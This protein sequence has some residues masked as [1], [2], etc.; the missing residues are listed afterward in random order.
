MQPLGGRPPTSAHYGDQEV[1]E[2]GRFKRSGVSGEQQFALA[3][4]VF[5]IFLAR[6]Q[7]APGSLELL[8]GEHTLAMQ[9]GE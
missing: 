2:K 8:V 3:P 9:L 7:S 4:A 1:R 6:E 5:A